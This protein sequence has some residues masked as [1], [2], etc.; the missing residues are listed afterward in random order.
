MDDFSAL[1]NYVSRHIALTE[2]DLEIFTL[3][4]FMFLLVLCITYSMKQTFYTVHPA[5]KLF[6]SHIMVMEITMEG[7]ARGQY[8]PFPPTPQHNINFYPGDAL[9][10]RKPSDIFSRAPDALLVGPQTTRVDLMMGR[11]HIIVSVA[12]NPGGLFRL[13]NIPMHELM[14]QPF[15]AADL[16]GREIYEVNERLREVNTHAEM[17]SVVEIYLL[18]KLRPAPLS[19]FERTMKELLRHPM[20]M[21]QAASASC[22]SLRQ[23]ERRSLQLLGYS[24]KFF[25]RLIRFSKAYRLKVNRPEAGWSSI[26]Y[27]CGYY[28]QMHLVKDFRAFTGTS[29][30]SL[31][32]EILLSPI[33]VQKD[34]GL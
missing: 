18:H 9:Y 24:P 32:R 30:G 33:Q 8:I 15:S 11:H 31:S 20:T 14:D 25:A 29:P 6:I 10:T 5:L 17:K 27:S 1:I 16:L 7:S 2:E 34:I 4:F 19:P 22:L 28:D 23:F 13:P 26:A 3:A 21:D 12:F